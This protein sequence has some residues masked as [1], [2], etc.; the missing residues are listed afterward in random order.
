MTTQMPYDERIG[1]IMNRLSLARKRAGLSLAQAAPLVGLKGASSLSPYE[2]GDYVP[3]L[4]LF[5]RMCEIYQVSP[6]WALLGVNP[7]FDMEVFFKLAG[8][9]TEETSRLADLLSSLSSDAE[10]TLARLP[11]AKGAE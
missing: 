4:T 9:I 6:V 2:T 7:A 11:A 1:Q 8:E 10:M 3:T 5:L